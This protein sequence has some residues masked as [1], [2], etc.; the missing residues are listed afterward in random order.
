MKRKGFIWFTGYIHHLRKPR[1]ELEVRP[2]RQELRQRSWR[3]D[4]DLIL[5]ASCSACLLIQPRITSPGIAMP[6]VGWALSHQPLIKKMAHIHDHRPSCWKQLLNRG[7]LWQGNS[8]CHKLT[9][10]HQHN[11]HAEICP[12]VHQCH[13]CSWGSQSL[14]DKT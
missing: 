5:V 9:K 6:T 2:C 1:E 3:N 4:S 14:S 13:S 8:V 12:L 10:T 11:R 7:S